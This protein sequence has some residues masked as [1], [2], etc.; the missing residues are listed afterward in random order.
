M[1]NENGTLSIVDRIK[2]L[3]KGP[4]GE[5]IALEKL[6]STYKNSSYIQNTCVYASKDVPKIIAIIELEPKLLEEKGVKCTKDEEFK[7]EVLNDLRSV[8]SKNG[9]KKYELVTDVIIGKEE[10]SPDN[11]M[12]TAAMKLNRNAIYK[13]YDSQIEKTLKN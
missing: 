3:V 9:L 13:H 6:E 1:W 5:Y 10:W 7:K 12:L 8:G 4:C 2:N 11:N